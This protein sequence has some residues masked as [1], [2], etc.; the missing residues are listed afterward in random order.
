MMTSRSVVRSNENV[1]GE[2]GT[3]FCARVINF[4]S[5]G[6]CRVRESCR[7]YDQARCLPMP[8]SVKAAPS[9]SVIV[10]IRGVL[11]SASSDPSPS[12]ANL[13][14]VEARGVEPPLSP[15]SIGLLAFVTATR[16]TTRWS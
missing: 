10:P 14:T 13:R 16:G 2:L 6:E 12:L 7:Y 9:G 5:V 15:P 1:N 8:F 4:V 3:R 11:S